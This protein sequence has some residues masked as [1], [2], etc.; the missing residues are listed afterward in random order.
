MF[1]NSSKEAKIIASQ[2]SETEKYFPPD[3]RWGMS[4]IFFSDA[5][6][7]ITRRQAKPEV[8]PQ[9]W[10]ATELNCKLFC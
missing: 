2:N 8:Q 4:A 5:L 7:A 10:E 3:S 9:S 6:F 1:T